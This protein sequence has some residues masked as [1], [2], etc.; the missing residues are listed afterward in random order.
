M[1]PKYVA[2]TTAAIADKYRLSILLELAQ[3]GSITITGAQEITGLSQPCVSHHVKLLVESGLVIS[4]KQG[5]C[6]NLSL[7]KDT[8]GE[9]GD[10]LKNLG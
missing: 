7:N 8:L 3:R 9:L 6:Q 1:E 10:F 5:R 4:E 2:K